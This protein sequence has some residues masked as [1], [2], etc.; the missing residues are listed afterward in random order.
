MNPFEI[1]GDVRH[2]KQESVRNDAASVKPLSTG[3]GLHKKLMT[4]YALPPYVS[5]APRAFGL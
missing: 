2:S 5:P 3:F 4:G 1:V